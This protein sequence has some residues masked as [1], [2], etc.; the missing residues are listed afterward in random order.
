MTITDIELGTKPPTFEEVVILPPDGTGD[1]VSLC[2]F[3]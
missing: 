2:F 3:L 1:L